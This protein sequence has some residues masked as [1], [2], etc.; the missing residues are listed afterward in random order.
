MAELQNS[1]DLESL[2]TYLYKIVY[3]NVSKILFVLYGK[4]C[5]GTKY[6]LKEF[7]EFSDLSNFIYENNLYVNRETFIDY[8]SLESQI[9]NAKEHLFKLDD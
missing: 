5:I 2:N 9:K 7:K 4:G 6:N 8:K 1:V 3:N